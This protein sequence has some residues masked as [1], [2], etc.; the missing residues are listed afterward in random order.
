[1]EYPD[2]DAFGVGSLF[3]YRSGYRRAVPQP[4]ERRLRRRVDRPVAGNRRSG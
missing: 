2:R 4:V 1:M 3:L